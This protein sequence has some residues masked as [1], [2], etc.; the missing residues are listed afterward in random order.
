MNKFLFRGKRLDNGEW[1][2]GNYVHQAFVPEGSKIVD[3]AI[4]PFGAYPVEVDPK[5]IGQYRDDIN[6]FDGDWIKA[7]TNK[8]PT[9]HVEGF[10]IY[11]DMECQIEQNDGNFPLVS[12][13]II[14]RLSVEVTG[15]N[16]YDSPELVT[17]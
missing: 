5:T 1:V 9:E 16:I 2:K 14:D 8:H 10:L 11:N 4:Q 12:F 3:H 15:K 13:A 17:S 7:K 6:A